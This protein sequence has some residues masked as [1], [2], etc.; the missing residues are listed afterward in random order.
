[1]FVDEVIGVGELAIADD[2]STEPEPQE[3]ARIV[4][5]ANNAG[6]MSNK[7]RQDAFSSWLKGKQT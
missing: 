7:M 2:R 4:S 3:L 6:M 1:M 5:E